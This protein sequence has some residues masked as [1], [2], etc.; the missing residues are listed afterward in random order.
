MSSVFGRNILLQAFNLIPHETIILRRFKEMIV[1]A[2]GLQ[3]PTYEDDI[4]IEATV[5]AVSTEIYKQLNLD[6]QKSYIYVHTPNELRGGNQVQVP[7][8]LAWDNREF[9]VYQNTNWYSYDN[10]TSAMAVEVVDAY[11]Q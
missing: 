3:V 4:D 5:Q 7:D 11:G 6:F 9:D 10:W 2:D 1:R 8:R